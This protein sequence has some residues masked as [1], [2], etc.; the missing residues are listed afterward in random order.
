MERRA[1]FK[2]IA[3]AGLVTAAGATA[4][5][6]QQSEG[7]GAPTEARGF[8]D[9]GLPALTDPGEPRGEMLYRRFGDT[10]AT[11]SAIGFGG[12]HFAKPAVSAK[13]GIR[14]CHQ[15]IDRGI[16]FMD[17][18]WDYNDG[19]SEEW[20]GRALSQNGYHDKVFLMSKV[21][22]R[23]AKVAREQLETSLRRLRTDTSTSGSSTRC[24]AS[25]TPTASSRRAARSRRR[26]RRSRPARSATSASPGT[27]T[28]TSTS[29]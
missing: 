24:C 4:R 12:S 3:A 9:A 13:E 28:R 16:T 15:A 5:A 22:G 10:G 8:G 27:R 25:K 17:N 7:T 2:G 18:A 1:L 19:T 14:L 20:M 21:D 29:P 26:W 6:A 11:V 23:T